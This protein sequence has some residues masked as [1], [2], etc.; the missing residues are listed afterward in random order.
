MIDF[1]VRRKI[2]LA[3]LYSNILEGYIY[4][5][6]PEGF[7]QNHERD[8]VYRSA[9]SRKSKSYDCWSTH[10]SDGYRRWYL[11]VVC[12]LMYERRYFVCALWKVLSTYTRF[13]SI[14]REPCEI[15]CQILRDFVLV[16]SRFVSIWFVILLAK[17]S[18]F[19][20]DSER[21]TAVKEDRRN[22]PD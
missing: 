18:H 17:T 7:L 2:I 8:T 13:C 11:H 6:R 19:V 3:Q 14:E 12:I 10:F 20:C 1:L 21:L 4:N 15:V 5:L 16:P 9:R 22:L